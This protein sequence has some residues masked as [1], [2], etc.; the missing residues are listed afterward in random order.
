MWGNKPLY[1]NAN[2]IE[3][4]YC[5]LY[6]TWV[7]GKEHMDSLFYSQFTNL[8]WYEM[9]DKKWTKRDVTIKVGDKKRLF[10]TMI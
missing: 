8:N 5:E 7:T 1:V 6:N 4:Y 2:N 10:T 3:L 9:F